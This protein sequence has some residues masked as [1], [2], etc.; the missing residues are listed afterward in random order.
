VVWG[1]VAVAMQ[2]SE[3]RLYRYEPQQG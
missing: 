1:A 3:Q 2:D